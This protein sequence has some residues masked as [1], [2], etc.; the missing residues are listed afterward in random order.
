M[1]FRHINLI[2][3][4]LPVYLILSEGNRGSLGSPRT[5]QITTTDI[6]IPGWT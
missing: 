6:P 4:T 5:L 2:V 3:Y 1:I